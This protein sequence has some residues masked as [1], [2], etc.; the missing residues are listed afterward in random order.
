MYWSDWVRY[1][2]KIEVANMDGSNRRVLVKSSL[3]LPNGLT[4]V[5]STNEL[6][7]TDAGTWSIR[8]VSLSDLSMRKV[9]Q[10]APYPFGITSFNR[11]LFWTDW[12]VGSIQRIGL[13]AERPGTP[14]SSFR[15]NTGKIFG[16]KGVQK[17]SR[18]GEFG[19]E[20]QATISN[21]FFNIIAF[22]FLE[23]RHLR[24]ILHIAILYYDLKPVDTFPPPPTPDQR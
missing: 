10:P 5:Q 16:I 22:Y 20:C 13:T 3:G 14:L 24:T 19:S 1:Q 11:T 18:S 23:T 21:L 12:M 2:P 9:L 8:C 4:L 6:C 15:G 7:F 17:C